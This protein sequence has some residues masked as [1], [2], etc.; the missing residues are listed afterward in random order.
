M[1]SEEWGLRHI[2]LYRLTETGSTEVGYGSSLITRGEAP[3][4]TSDERVLIWRCSFDP[5]LNILEQHRATDR[6]DDVV[7]RL[8]DK[9]LREGALAEALTQDL[10][11]Y[12]TAESFVE[13]EEEED[14]QSATTDLDGE[15]AEVW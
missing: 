7:T 13:L 15:I 1:E 4:T 10:V 8:R 11:G 14:G 6:V 3:G 2:G 5:P 9:E 12:A